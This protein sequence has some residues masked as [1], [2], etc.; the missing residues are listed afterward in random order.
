MARQFTLP[1]ATAILA[2]SLCMGT[3]AH[4]QT[5]SDYASPSPASPLLVSD[6]VDAEAGPTTVDP[7]TQRGNRRGGRGRDAE[8]GP[9]RARVDVSPYI[10]VGQVLT[11]DF[12]TDDV[13]TY[14]TV[15]VGVETSVSTR[16]AQLAA[17]VRY[18]RR[19]GWDDRILDS[20][21]VSGIARGRYT[22]GQGLQLEAGA[23]ATRSSIDGRGGTAD[24][25]AGDRSNSANTY[26]IYAGPTFGRR[27]GDLDVGGA[28]RFGYSRQD[29]ELQ[30]TLIGGTRPIG[31]FEDSINHAAIASVGMSPG[32]LP[33]G[34]RVSGGY[35]REEAGQ[36]DQRYEGWHVRSDLTLPVSPTLA[37]VG[38][39]GYEDIEVSYRPP[40]VNAVTG[41]P[42]TDSN[43]RLIAD[44]AQPRR[45]AFETDG[46]IWDAG[47]LWRPSPRVS[48]EGRVGRRYGDWSFT[49][50]ASW[51]ASQDTGYQLGIY[52]SLGTVGRS[53]TAGLA[54]LPTDLEVFRNG[55]DGSIGSCAFGGAGGTCLT[56]TLGNATGFAF[57][58]RGAVF[59]VST[60]SRLWTMGAAF[61]YD[62][63]TY[64]AS[65]L[66]AVPGLDGAV[67]ETFF[68]YLTASRPI[69]D[70]T[71]FG[72]AG[73]A[74]LLD[75]AFGADALSA[76]ASA[77]LGHS[78]LP[79]LQGNAA[80]SI[81][82]IDQDGFNSRVFGAAQVG[83]RYT[84]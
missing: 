75:G 36:L 41:I 71:T 37:L 67:D 15:A 83:L 58:N 73:Y 10:E 76:G 30:P 53:L 3:G 65:G 16:R 14:S 54:A 47:V 9:A 48:V 72:M 25:L 39:V 34:W 49:G 40:V 80:V 64:V 79:R 59:S 77:S 13:L 45:I 84:F 46:L 63:R 20:D 68:T 52:D 21:V 35:E 66:T 57:R 82:T 28:Y 60:R 27:F 12:N 74:T 38:G 4:A 51:M 70:R 62:R 5:V 69:S 7:R 22:V 44:T 55:I 50:S 23:L 61:G 24:F 42:T 43:G 17:D 32:R 78:F 26:A 19:I 8:Q 56:P 18:E 31:S 2:A 6:P 11:A 33:F 81:N 29:V 1:T